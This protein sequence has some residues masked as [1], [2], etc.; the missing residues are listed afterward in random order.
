VFDVI[1]PKH[2]E[3]QAS[4]AH[5]VL[6]SASMTCNMSSEGLWAPW[7]ATAGPTTPE[8]RILTCFL[9]VFSSSDAITMQ[10]SEPAQAN[11]II[12]TRTGVLLWA[13][14]ST[15]RHAYLLLSTAQSKPQSL[16]HARLIS[17][18]RPFHRDAIVL[19][20]C[21]AAQHRPCC[22]SE[23]YHNCPN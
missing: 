19:S 15:A 21:F 2:S 11:R 3:Q 8:K 1:A 13:S 23:Q 17:H 22:T 20:P 7:T 16:Q 4:L 5:Y 6:S 12:G 9:Q 18:I 14:R 10:G